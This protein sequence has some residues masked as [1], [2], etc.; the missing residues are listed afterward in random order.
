[1]GVTALPP[2]IRLE[3]DA[4]LAAQVMCVRDLTAIQSLRVDYGAPPG[5]A[6][7]RFPTAEKL[8]EPRPVLNQF[9]AILPKPNVIYVRVGPVG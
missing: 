6:E 4:R 9:T 7:F 8:A 1:M 3:D 5:Q 2:S